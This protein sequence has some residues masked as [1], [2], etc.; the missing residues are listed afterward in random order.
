MKTKY[1]E[2][3]KHTNKWWD[4]KVQRKERVTHFKLWQQMQ[5]FVKNNAFPHTFNVAQWTIDYAVHENK[6]LAAEKRVYQN[7]CLSC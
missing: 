1:L 4:H 6:V 5:R 3:N 2:L 7:L